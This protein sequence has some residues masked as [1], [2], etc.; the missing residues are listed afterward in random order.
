MGRNKGLC[1]ICGKGTKLTFEHVPPQAAGN[2]PD[3][4]I[5]GIADWLNRDIKSGLLSGGYLEP[6]GT[7][8]ITICKHCNEYSG[9]FYVPEFARFVTAGFGVLH[10][11]G[12]S[13]IDGADQSLE[14]PLVVE[15]NTGQM[16]ALPVV[17]Q[18]VAS[19]LA[20]NAPTF[21]QA[22][23]ALV[24]F[25]LDRQ[26]TGLPGNYHLYLSLFAGPVGRFVGLGVQIDTASGQ[27]VFL[28]EVAYPPYAY[29][30]TVDSEP[31]QPVGDIGVWASRGFDDVQDDRL[32]LTLGFGHTPYPGDYR[33]MARVK[34]ESETA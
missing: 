10:H 26:R 18:I 25:V 17:K 34:A 11:L 15:F 1:A 2:Q 21:A 31:R 23:P 19:L 13:T 20:V 14:P 9:Q 7:G 32:R 24:D 16:R 6:K 30:L 22:H 27:S 8:G 28:T 29:L 3:A 12:E 4:V 5:Y 33:S